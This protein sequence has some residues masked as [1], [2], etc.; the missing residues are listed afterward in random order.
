MW[1][2][3]PTLCSKEIP[4]CL[5]LS[6]LFVCLF[7]F[8]ADS[9][10]APAFVVLPTVVIARA[11][12]TS[13]AKIT[14]A[15]SFLRT[16]FPSCSVQNGSNLQPQCWM[17]HGTK[18]QNDQFCVGK[19]EEKDVLPQLEAFLPLS[20]FNNYKTKQPKQML[21]SGMQ[22]CEF[23]QTRRK[24]AAL[25]GAPGPCCCQKETSL[26]RCCNPCAQ[27]AQSPGRA[28]PKSN[29]TNVSQLLKTHQDR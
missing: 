22:R 17:S 3:V 6:G 14:T 10:R 18:R 28:T 29:D 9:V 12:P 11:T 21:E 16:R 5:V 25:C 15:L 27:H 7:V 8:L 24:Q 26:G 23:I 2:V 13:L 1:C 19:S 4:G 20:L